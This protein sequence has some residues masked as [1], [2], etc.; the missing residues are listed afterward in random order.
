ML[1]MSDHGNGYL[2]GFQ[3]STSN[4]HMRL[5]DIPDGI[6]RS[7]L[8]LDVIAF[9]ACL[10]GMH[11]VGLALRGVADVMV[12][13]QEAEPATGYDYDGML[14][15]LHEKPTST[16]FEVGD[17]IGSTFAASN[18]DASRVR[19]V[20]TST[21]DL[22]KLPAFNEQLANFAA[23]AI[24]DQTADR[25]RVQ[26]AVDNVDI[27]RF[28]DRSSADLNSA[29]E[30]FGAL[31]DSEVQGPA[32]DLQTWLTDNEVIRSNHATG[33]L[34]SVGGMAIFLPQLSNYAAGS[35][36]SLYTTET[37]F[38][39]L[40]PWHTFARTLVAEDPPPVKPGEGAVDWFSAV[41]TWGSSPNGP[42][43]GADLDI[44]VYE[45]G[46]DFGTPANG[47]TSGN[48]FLS[49]DSYDTELAQESY[50]LQPKH[51]AGTYIVLVHL[52]DIPKGEKAYP[53]L[54]IYR[55]DLPGGSRTLL[56][57]KVE[58]RKLVE[59]PMDLS[60]ELTTTI[61]KDNIQGVFDLE[62]SNLW[63]ATTIEVVEKNAEQE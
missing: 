31:G 19:G 34:Q 35:T 45:P 10:M 18:E 46:G 6:S 14:L 12:A 40:Q 3:D 53:R 13:S 62:Y 29:L 22:S 49:G 20:T 54:Q 57:A 9:D 63:Y 47:T 50:E 7:G 33:D 42:E 28:M 36:V 58:D 16:A 52:Y 39:P 24:R 61:S 38:L 21:V 56:R 2:G 26:G 32:Q 5:R 27:I 55:P 41:L 17:L 60:R 4:G 11:E 51:A 44:Y 15:G 1:I 43:S 48:G 59:V 30:V 25:T 37:S 8:H 23:S